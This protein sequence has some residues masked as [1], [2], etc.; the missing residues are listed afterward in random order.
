M[1][2]RGEAE[3]PVK[4][5]FFTTRE[6]TIRRDVALRSL[7]GKSLIRTHL[8]SALVDSA[9]HPLYAVHRTAADVQIYE[10]R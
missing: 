2:M 8:R 9:P 5:S 10:E 3:I 6:L 1:R 4:S 7:G